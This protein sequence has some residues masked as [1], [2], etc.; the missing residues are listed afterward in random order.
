MALNWAI[1]IGFVLVFDFTTVML[2][3]ALFV[4][5]AT[6]DLN[7]SKATLTGLN[8]NVTVTCGASGAK[9][10]LRNFLCADEVAFRCKPSR[11]HVAGGPIL[12]IFKN[13]Q[14]H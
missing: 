2:A 9:I 1:K 10:S 5:R 7:I 3:S 14:Q 13:M 6:T 12:R 11:D 8:T 4:V